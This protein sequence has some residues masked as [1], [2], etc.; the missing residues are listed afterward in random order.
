MPLLS[1]KNSPRLYIKLQARFSL[2]PK[3]VIINS[4]LSK[5]EP[6]FLEEQR[7]PNW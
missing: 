3:V 1:E 5:D 7:T 4:G 6:A 2:A